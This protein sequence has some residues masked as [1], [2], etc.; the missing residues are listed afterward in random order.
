[1]NKRRSGAPRNLTWRS[2]RK[3]RSSFNRPD[4]SGFRKRQRVRLRNRKRRDQRSLVFD[5]PTITKITEQRRSPNRRNVFL[6]G[7]FAFGCNL[8]VVAR[9]RLRAGMSLTAE[10]VREIEHGEVKQ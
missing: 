6:D 9:F 7:K 2:C 4:L 10:Q 8:N 5:M 1:M 3:R